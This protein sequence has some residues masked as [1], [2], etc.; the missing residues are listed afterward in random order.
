MAS[1]GLTQ[2]CGCSLPVMAPGAALLPSEQQTVTALPLLPTH[3]IDF[4]WKFGSLLAES[5]TLACRTKEPHS[6][7][8]G[9]KKTC[10]EKSEHSLQVQL[11]S[12]PIV[13]S[14]TLW[15]A[16]DAQAADTNAQV[17]GT[18]SLS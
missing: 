6:E 10:S 12:V 7:P 14:K 16:F 11:H 9:R 1:V 4:R 2:T 18:T 13:Q 17:E 5:P 3:H 8:S 15:E